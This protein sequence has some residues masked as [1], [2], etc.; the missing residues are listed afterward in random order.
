MLAD[1]NFAFAVLRRRQIVPPAELLQDPRRSLA[2]APGVI[3]CGAVSVC[4]P[5]VRPV[6]AVESILDVDPRLADQIV[7]RRCV[8][9]PHLN[10]QHVI[11]RKTRLDLEQTVR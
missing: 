6:S 2:I 10:R 7:R 11:P 3:T 8:E 4:N 5:A 9:I 1:L